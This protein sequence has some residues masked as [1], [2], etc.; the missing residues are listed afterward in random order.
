MAES[1]YEYNGP[2]D[3]LALKPN[4]ALR[5][6]GGVAAAKVGNRAKAG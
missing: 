4:V 2:K 5:T 6:Y 1:G 3:Y